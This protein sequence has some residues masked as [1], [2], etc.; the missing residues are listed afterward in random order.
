[1]RLYQSKLELSDIHIV[2]AEEK[3]K[4]VDKVF[5]ILGITLDDLKKSCKN[6]FVKLNT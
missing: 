4:E 6:A 1:M 2:K 5:N 3:L